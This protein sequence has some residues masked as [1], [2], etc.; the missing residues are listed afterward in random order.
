[1]QSRLIAK[2]HQC[3][4]LQ[5]C[6]VEKLGRTPSIFLQQLHY[7]LTSEKNVGKIF[8]EKKWVYNSTKA[9]ALQLCL[10]ERQ[11][12]RVIN[13]LKELGIIL[14]NQLSQLKSDRTNWY[15]INY[16]VLEGMLPNL[17]LN[18]KEINHS[19]G[20]GNNSSGE[21]TDK[22]ST[23][24]RHSD[25][26]Y[27]KETE[28]TSENKTIS[29]EEI[30]L[31][32]PESRSQQVNFVKEDINLKNKNNLATELLE[33]WNQ[34]VGQGA[35]LTQLTKKRAQHLVAAFKY[36]FE[37][38]LEKWKHFCQQIT[39]SDF[40]MG[41]VKETFRASLDWVL[42]FDIIQRIIEGD[43][44][45]KLKNFI[46]NDHAIEE[47]FEAISREIDSTDD[48]I[49]VKALRKKILHKFERV[50]YQSW[51]KDL[52][53]TIEEHGSEVKLQVGG[54]FIKD[55]IETHYLRDLHSLTPKNIHIFCRQLR[56][57]S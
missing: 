47:S 18:P 48:T 21:N 23:S 8:Q 3:L 9:W 2:Q 10:S 41:K 20:K 5:P 29:S 28:I 38:S 52:H 45:I 53:I 43:F 12:S 42:R 46:Q 39:T 13:H 15:T 54:A 11:V 27:H 49:E 44:G 25:R 7:W 51:F 1:M 19:L 17:S 57:E 6:L 31:E 4:I 56:K 24:P 26:V 14:I 35:S 40:L 32:K 30:A 16:H 50:L 37:S 33:I 22:M 55:Y 36:R 34:T